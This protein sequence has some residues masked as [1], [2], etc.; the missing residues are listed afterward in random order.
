MENF[1]FEKIFIGCIY[2][3]VGIGVSI[4]LFKTL[5]EKSED[6]VLD[7][8]FK[9]SIGILIILLFF[10]T[11]YSGKLLDYIILPLTLYKIYKN[12]KYNR[13]GF[14][15]YIAG[16]LGAI[17]LSSIGAFEWKGI[18][19]SFF[20]TTTVFLLPLYL[21][22]FKFSKEDR[23]SFLDVG[24]LAFLGKLSLSFLEK[25][26][27][28]SGLYGGERI[29]GGIQVWRYAPILMIGI[30]VI[31]ALLLFRR[32]K[33]NEMT[34]LILLLIPS[35]I[36]LVRTQNRGNWVGLL[37]AIALGVL[38]KY[39]EKSIYLL[40]V[41]SIFLGSLIY[42]F[43][44]NRY[45]RRATSIVNLKNDIS[46][47]G[48]LEHWKQSIRMFKESP[49]NGVG[50]SEKNFKNSENPE[51]YIYVPKIKHGHSHSN[52]FYLLATMGILG[53]VSYGIFIIKSLVFSFKKGEI[54]YYI[55]FLV[56]VSVQIF[57]LFETPIKYEDISSMMLL[58]LGLLIADIAGK[59]RI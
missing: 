25:W 40:L 4:D 35:I 45:S 13:T 34:A 10:T 53:I 55:S 27:Y 56:I 22:Q 37:G 1:L 36:A 46:N 20:D 59:R 43:P 50:Y 7:R 39:R 5:K 3:I 8:V 12:K 33:K 32:N 21:G 30:V 42:K 15:W 31:F 41:C 48:R 11:K 57:S 52:I 44:E 51:D 47:L 28:I 2:L 24:I 26:K 23:R 18:R 6:S 58:M 49:I 9:F 38:I 16:F 14:E 19:D 29:S 54:D 17:L